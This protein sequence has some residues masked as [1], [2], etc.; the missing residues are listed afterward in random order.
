MQSEGFKWQHLPKK[1]K[2]SQPSPPHDLS[3]WGDI[4]DSESPEF[5]PLFDQ[6]LLVDGDE[7]EGDEEE[8]E[9]MLARLLRAE[10]DN[11]DDDAILSAVQA[12]RP[13]S[14]Q[15]GDVASTVVDC[16]LVKVCKYAAAKLGITWPV[17]PSG[18]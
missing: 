5:A 13:V 12:S 10:P 4:I 14:V 16:D 11:E 3:L 2:D 9:Q 15:S 18:S 7:L 8:D 6:Q 1:I 17:T